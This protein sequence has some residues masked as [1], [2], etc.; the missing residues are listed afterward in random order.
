MP[1]ISIITAAYAPRAQYLS[2]TAKSVAAQTL[3][4][5]WRFEWI[6]QE[7]GATPALEN[8]KMMP[9]V[10]YE[11]N[12]RQLGIPATRN[13]ALSRASGELVQVLDHD[14]I[15][16][17][18]CLST[19]LKYFTSHPIHWA[20]GQAD[21]LM[22]DG[23]RLTYPPALSFGLIPASVVNKWATKH[24][25]NWPIHCGGLMMRT[26]TV[27]ALGGWAGLPAEDDISLLAAITEVT[28]G[29]FDKTTTWLYRQ[30]LKQ[31]YRT[32]EWRAQ[33]AVGRRI[34]LQRA[35][36]MRRLNLQIG[37]KS[38]TLERTT[39]A[40]TVGPSVKVPRLLDEASTDTPL[41]PP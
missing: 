41:S 14:D 33:S 25:G 21:D 5:G 29:Y 26:A 15:L 22:P 3:P 32:T 36:A 10:R 31:T 6:I 27:R 7:D 23:T 11:A 8:F 35:Q 9:H 13:L 17:P 18:E 40:V 19:L 39:D 24:Q 38:F 4:T 30:H 1:L 20:I 34:A 16:L 12:N 2:V 28:N 37:S